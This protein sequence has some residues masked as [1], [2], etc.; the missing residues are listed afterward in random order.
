MKP[1][2]QVIK[3]LAMAFAIFLCISIIGGVLSIAG[4]FIDDDENTGDIKNYSVNE[5]VNEL[6][7]DIK[8]ADFKITSGSSFSIDSNINNLKIYEKEG[9]LQILE[10]G[11]KWF[12]NTHNGSKIIVTV[13]YGTVFNEADIETGAG[14][15]DID[16]L[17]ADKLKL[18]LG[19]GKT[20]IN[21]LNAFYETEIDGGVGELVIKNGNLNNL[22][23]DMGIGQLRFAGEI[24]GNSSI[25]NGIGSSDFILNGSKDDYRIHIEKGIGSAEVDG[26]KMKDG[27]VYGQGNNRIDI[28]GGIGKINIEFEY[29]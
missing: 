17:S 13:P 26:E 19:A 29:Q 24:K 15:V 12:G 21:E 6:E 7:I 3:Y 18:S 4:I 22:K 25:D 10:E 5:T 28:D 23:L 14:S 1:W 16:T 11:H 20:H 9:C 8:A 2:Q 27:A